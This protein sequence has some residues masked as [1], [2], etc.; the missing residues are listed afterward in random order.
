[1]P[2]N[3]QL[4][5]PVHRTLPW[6]AVGAAGGAG[7]LLAALTRTGETAEQLSLPLLRA[8]VLA[9][10]LGLVFLLDDPARHTTATVPT[11]RPLR[12]ALRTALVVPAAA[13]WWTVALL[14]VPP[15]VRPPV[16]D[17]T[18]EAGAAFALA[19]TGAAA[20]VRFTEATRPGL[21][22]AAALLTTAVLALLLWPERWALFVPVEDERWAAAHDRWGVVLAGTVILGAWCA[23]EPVRRR[24]RL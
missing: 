4:L 15:D 11:P 8:A 9:F 17:L 23:L 5:L 19:V 14:L 22:V 2:V 16:G 20:A 3:R 18:L 6:G 12:I 24:I 7:L 1:M 10:A 21:P 13:A